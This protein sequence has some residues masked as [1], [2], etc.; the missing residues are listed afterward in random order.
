MKKTTQLTLFLVG[1][2]GMMGVITAV[3]QPKPIAAQTID[4][5]FG[6]IESFWLPAEAAEL[7]VG[8]DRI[9]FYWNEIQPT[10][11]GDWNPLHV[12]EEWLNEA[13]ANGRQILGL[14]KNTPAWATDGEVA[15]G[16]PRGLYLPV[17]DPG[18]LWASYVRLVAQKY[19]PFGVHNWI[20]WN[21]P[22]IAPNVYGHE[23]A[24]S[25]E[26]YYQMVKVAYQVM[27][28]VD[29]Q[30]RI[31]IGGM[32]HWHD[33][34]YLRRFLQVVV[35]DPEAAANNYFFDALTYHIYF[36]PETISS[37][38]GNGFAIQQQ[39]GINPMKE[40]WVN[41]TNARPSMD[42]GWPVQVQEFNI[43]LEQQAWYVPQAMALGFYAGASHMGF[44]KL[45]DVNM[46]PGDESWG[47]IR[48]H[49]FSKRPAFYAYKNTIEYL[50]GFQYPIHREQ[51]ANH[52]LFTFTRPQGVTRIMWTRTPAA[53]DLRVPALAAS[54]VLVDPIT[55]EE[56]A[57]T[58]TDG[59]YD[60]HL[61]GQR[62]H[63]GECLMGGPPVFL[64][65]EGVA[66]DAIPTSPPPAVGVAATPI[67]TGQAA[68]TAMGTVTN[69]V[70]ATTAA[71]T[72]TVTFTPTETATPRPS[73]TP[74][75]TT[76]NT[77]VPT[78][79]SIPPTNTAPATEVA[80]LSPTATPE[81]VDTAVAGIIPTD[82]A[83]Y[84]FLGIGIGL[85]ILLIGIVILR[86]R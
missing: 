19:A 78:E 74:S 62:C 67:P 15:S 1:L 26:D 66:P 68:P 77:A 51:S 20:I 85:G 84:W 12:R 30:A 10:G 71:V 7:G 52:Y 45:V 70:A 60:I 65:E 6:A 5:R 27:K 4:P 82:Q 83:S 47:L 86:R 31:H 39:M 13:N 41:E 40:I 56:T 2:L 55:G 34:Q 48:P 11:P 23:F 61:G 35:A 16:V 18:N 43:D 72:A 25:T 9:L 32:T 22:D 54:G 14:L 49:D 8:W 53:V 29:P 46:N 63:G 36:R 38:V 50:A 73:N 64:V 37:I 28:Q 21:E 42:P 59:F 17:N 58:P 80:A 81:E 24:G 44:Y 33:P 57:V 3:T 69:T 75:P 79:T 76:T